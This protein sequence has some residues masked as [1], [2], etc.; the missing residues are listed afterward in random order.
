MTANTNFY[1]ELKQKQELKKN[2][3]ASSISEEIQL[4]AEQL[5]A[6]N[7]KLASQAKERLLKAQQTQKETGKEL[8][9]QG[10]KLKSAKK[11]IKQVHRNVIE[12]EKIAKEIKSEKAF[13]KVPGRKMF[14]SRLETISD[15]SESKEDGVRKI[16]KKHASIDPN[17]FEEENESV[18]GEAA[19][20]RE[21]GKISN[22][23]GNM[24]MEA[25]NQAQETKKQIKDIKKITKRNEKAEVAIER[26]NKKMD[27]L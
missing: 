7:L 21:L 27:E 1:Q 12:G 17:A 5:E 11:N 2:Q 6:E 13:F 16:P 20:N 9:A 25:E 23:L 4:K 8:K 18:K 14:D 26:T 15:D 3:S 10:T 19:T 22:I 24:Q